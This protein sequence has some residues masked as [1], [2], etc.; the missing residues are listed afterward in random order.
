MFFPTKN[1]RIESNGALVSTV[2][3]QPNCA[4][5]HYTA[6]E[7]PASDHASPLIV[8][9]CGFITAHPSISVSYHTSHRLSARS[10]ML[11]LERESFGTS[12]FFSRVP[13]LRTAVSIAVW[14][15]LALSSTPSV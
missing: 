12:D 11:S 14:R 4:T 8:P 2:L 6:N 3:S 7:H 15:V 10:V 1:I 9:F 13:S 5:V